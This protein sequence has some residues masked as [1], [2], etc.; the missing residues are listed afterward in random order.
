M[1]EVVI[2]Q[3][4]SKLNNSDPKDCIDIKEIIEMEQKTSSQFYVDSF[5]IYAS[6]TAQATIEMCRIVAEAKNNLIKERFQT[7]CTEIGHQKE[8]ATIRKYIVIGNHYQQ[9]IKYVELLPNSWTS[10]Y[11]ITQLPAEVFDALVLTNNSMANMTA[12]QIKALMAPPAVTSILSHK[13]DE[14]LS[15]KHEPIK[16]SGLSAASTDIAGASGTANTDMSTSCISNTAESFANTNKVPASIS[17]LKSDQ[18]DELSIPPI[19]REFAQQATSKIMADA[20]AA[21][22]RDTVESEQPFV[23]YRMVI[24][25][26]S[27]LPE[28][29]AKELT[30]TLTA[31]KVKHRL[32]LTFF[33]DEVVSV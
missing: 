10:I 30:E 7:F 14:S 1:N 26:N 29:A 21:S 27:K 3:P 32:D 17:A 15:K 6:K 19:D 22:K 4:C 33:N 25:F 11:L 16:N 9:F 2:S 5:K 28:I 13:K 18:E 23:P 8:D 12:A 24:R 31:F 20:R